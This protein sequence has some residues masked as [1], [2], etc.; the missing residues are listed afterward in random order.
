MPR[1]QP[2]KVKLTNLCNNNC[3]VCHILDKKASKNKSLSEIKKELERIRKEYSELIITGGEPTVRKDLID[4]IKCVKQLDFYHI[5]LR[6]NG[7]MFSYLNYCEEIIKAGVDCFEIY[8]YGHTAKLHDSITRVPGSFNQTVQGIEN[9]KKLNQYVIVNVIITKQNYEH[10]SKITQLVININVDL[11]S[12]EYINP[13]KKVKNDNLI[14]ISSQ[15]MN[16]INKSLDSKFE[17]YNWDGHVFVKELPIKP[18]VD[19][20][21]I[22]KTLSEIKSIKHKFQEELNKICDT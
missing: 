15:L 10:L 12:L 2:F 3:I 8:L 5:T 9:L 20:K 19:I 1:K 13:K 4:I 6:T 11:I 7:R 21:K 18:S 16:E 17:K 22:Y 14:G